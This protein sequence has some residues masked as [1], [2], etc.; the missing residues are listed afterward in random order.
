MQELRHFQLIN[1]SED[2]SLDYELMWP[3]H[4]VTVTPDHGTVAPCSTVAVCV[5]P[6]ATSNVSTAAASLPWS[7]AINVTCDGQHKVSGDMRRN[8]YFVVGAHCIV[9]ELGT[10]MRVIAGSNPAQSKTQI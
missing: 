4:R 6:A 7:G 10:S 5:S 8:I 2:H 1:Y 3:G 9:I